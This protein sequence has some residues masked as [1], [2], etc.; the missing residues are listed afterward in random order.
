MS[1]IEELRQN[2]PETN[3]ITIVLL[4]ENSDADLAQALEGNA[5]VTE[6]GLDLEA[7]QRAEWNSLLSVIATRTNLETVKLLD[8]FGAERRKAPAMLV[9]SILRAIQRNTAIRNVELEWLRLPT[10]IST[11]VDNASSIASFSLSKCVGEQGASDL[12]AAIQRNTNIETLNLSDLED[13]YSFPIL[14]GLR[15]NVSLK[16]FIF[17][18]NPARN[19]SDE[20]SHAI[21]QILGSKTSIQRLEW[22]E[23]TLSD[24]IA[25]GITYSESVSEL[26]F[27]WCRFEDQSNFAHFRSILQNKRNLTSL[28]LD[29]CSFGRGQVHED[30]ISILLR[31]DSLL[32]CF[33]FRNHPLREWAF[34]GVQFKNLLQG[35]QKSKLLERFRIETIQTPH[36][37]QTLT[38]SIPSMRIR[39]LEVAFAGQFGRDSINPRQNLLLAVKNN[40]SLR[41]VKGVFRY[42]NFNLFES[43]EDK[44]TLAFYANRNEC[45]DQWVEKPETVKQKVWPDALGLA[46]RA[47]PNA[48]F[49]GLRSVLG[50]DYVSLPGGGLKRKHRQYQVPS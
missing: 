27:S 13:T 43:V 15:S 9:R 21:H 41:P 14:E 36:Q 29:R 10:D 20:T 28:F 5:F 7:E 50:R 37:L 38:Q 18:S 19:L 2:N 40:F 31:P 30:V 24:E 8:A 25:Q 22:S 16:T 49:R 17:Y 34:L 44:K 11:F 47:G 33:E 48:L 26:K 32:R 12:A 46:E 45:L 39:E 1:V 42:Q 6:I 35:I 3:C 4:R 23:A